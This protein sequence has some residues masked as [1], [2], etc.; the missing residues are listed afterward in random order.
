MSAISSISEMS[1]S[2]ALLSSPEAELSSDALLSLPEAIK[3]EEILK[4]VRGSVRSYEHI[5]PTSEMGPFTI[6][7]V[8]SGEGFKKYGARFLKYVKHHILLIKSRMAATFINK[9]IRNTKAT[10][11]LVLNYS[12]SKVG[13]GECGEI[14]HAVG[15]KAFKA[16]LPEVFILIL[17]SS[18]STNRHMLPIFGKGVEQELEQAIKNDDFST[19]NSIEVKENLKS[20]MILDGLLFTKPIAARDIRKCPELFNYLTVSKIDKVE[21]TIRFKKL[22]EDGLDDCLKKADVM[23]AQIVQL[24]PSVPT[25]SPFEEAIKKHELPICATELEKRFPGTEWKKNDKAQTIWC[26]GTKEQTEEI[27]AYLKKHGIEAKASATKN[28]THIV[29]ITN[30]NYDL[31]EKLPP[32]SQKKEEKKNEKDC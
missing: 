20:G 29:M 25:L 10:D 27:A 17:I 18:T 30:P 24:L 22:T 12:V 26:E 23:H 31:I 19:K 8:I 6:D 15:I 7:L 32:L 1:S 14:S 9:G 4:D 21:A 5:I 3:G 11:Y 2:Q 13:E 28:K 16:K